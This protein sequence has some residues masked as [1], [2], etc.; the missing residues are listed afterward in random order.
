ME[1]EDVLEK[2]MEQNKMF[3][4]EGSAGLSN[5]CKIA[6][7][8]GYKDSMHS[9]QMSS[10]ECLGSLANLLEDNP[11]CI[12]AILGWIEDNMD[13]EWVE[14]LGISLKTEEENE[15]D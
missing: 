1:L 6:R 3:H 7:V 15:Y 10:G 5:L 2:Y 13:E 9:G 12:E 8:I 4:V 11:G 14:N